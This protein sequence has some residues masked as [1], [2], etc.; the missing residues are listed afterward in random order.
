MC[1]HNEVIISSGSTWCV[2]CGES[3]GA[4]FK[5]EFYLQD[6]ENNE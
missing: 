1:R 4:I 6:E 5:P 3:M 2:E